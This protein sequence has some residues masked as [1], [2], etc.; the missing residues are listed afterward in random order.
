MVTPP[1][2]FPSPA[3]AADD[4]S[5]P[6]PRTAK[7]DPLEGFDEFWHHFP[8]KV[9][10]EDAKRAY[11]KALK[12]GA[13][14][15]EIADGAMAYAADC[16]LVEDPHFIKHP[17][18]WLNGGRWADSRASPRS[19]PDASEPLP[20]LP[21]WCGQCGGASGPAA[22]SNANF[23]LVDGHPCPDCHPLTQKASTT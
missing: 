11:A 18:G 21:A 16:R 9:G 10:K 17:S 22:R 14:P 1:A 7:P 19:S 8:K 6:K 2:L 20:P 13:K 12:A 5:A 3:D 15:R 4:T 23:R